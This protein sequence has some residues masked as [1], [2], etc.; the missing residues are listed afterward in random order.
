MNNKPE[1]ELVG[2]KRFMKDLKRYYVNLEELKTL[3]ES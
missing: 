3:L 1:D 2:N